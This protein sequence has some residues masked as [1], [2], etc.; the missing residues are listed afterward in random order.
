MRLRSALTRNPMQSGIEMH[1][2]LILECL[3]K[4]NGFVTDPANQRPPI[5]RSFG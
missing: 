4:V 1:C 2:Y 3:E 5:V